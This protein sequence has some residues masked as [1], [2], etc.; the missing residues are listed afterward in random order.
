MVF[1]HILYN[2][3]KYL[4]APLKM[5][6]QF[7]SDLWACFFSYQFSF[8]V[9]TIKNYNST[10]YY[11]SFMC[12]INFNPKLLISKIC[13][14]VFQGKEIGRN[15]F[16]RV[17]CLEHRLS[18]LL[19]RSTSLNFTFIIPFFHLLLLSLVPLKAQFGFYS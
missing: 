8:S 4:L 16:P 3:L 11:N 18:F 9:K 13:M 2:H 12:N 7:S 19:V 17:G 10:F 5:R 6:L 1:F 15:S 14:C